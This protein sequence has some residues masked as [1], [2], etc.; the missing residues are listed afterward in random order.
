[1][2]SWAIVIHVVAGL[3]AGLF[4]GAMVAAAAIWGYGAA[5]D[6][7]TVSL[8]PS[9]YQAS[10]GQRCACGRAWARNERHA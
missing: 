4:I 10:L 5:L 6:G 9:S 2:H 7:D 3:L 1:M 8:A